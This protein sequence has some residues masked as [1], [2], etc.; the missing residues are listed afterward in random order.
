[1]QGYILEPKK[2]SGDSHRTG[3]GLIRVI[4]T[5]QGEGLI[6]VIATAQGKV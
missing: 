1:V 3:E 5:A 2:G 6:R 4:A